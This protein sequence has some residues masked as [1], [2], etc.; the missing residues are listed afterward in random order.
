MK[1][2]KEKF[3]LTNFFSV[4]ISDS[5]LIFTDH[6]QVSAFLKTLFIILSL[7]EFENIRFSLNLD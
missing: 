6:I 4:R 1:K 3:G 2:T 5:S 7:I